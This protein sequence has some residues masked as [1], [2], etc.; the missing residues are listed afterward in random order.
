M[1]TDTKI[2]DKIQKLLALA[3]RAGTPEE[4]GTAYALAQKLIT[5]HA[6][7]LATLR[8]AGS[9]DETITHRLIHTFSGRSCPTWIG[10]VANVLARVNGC[11]VFHRPSAHG[12]V[13]HGSDLAIG[14]VEQLLKSVVW[15]IDRLAKSWGA[16]LAY[17]PGRTGLNNFRIGAAQVVCERLKASAA[18]TI[19][20][21]RVGGASSTALVHV[22]SGAAALAKRDAERGNNLRAKSSTFRGDADARAAGQAAGARVSLMA[23]G[24]ALGAGK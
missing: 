3:E 8:A 17:S 9:A 19:E 4:A 1:S 13:C 5:E 21:A 22:Q 23:P 18:E 24:R 15:Q 2:A 11:Y 12:L 6:I 14:V 20:R 10:M 7:D 16:G